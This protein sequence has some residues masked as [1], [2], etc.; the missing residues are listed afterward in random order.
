M[1]SVKVYKLKAKFKEL[2]VKS[3]VT[4][5]RVKCYDLGIKKG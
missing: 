3:S 2:N 1:L 4:C 5:L